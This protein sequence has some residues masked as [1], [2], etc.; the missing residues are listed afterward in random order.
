MEPA[1]HMGHVYL[2]PH[3][4]NKWTTNAIVILVPHYA[5]STATETVSAWPKS[6]VYPFFDVLNQIDFSSESGIANEILKNEPNSRLF[7]LLIFLRFSENEL[8]LKQKCN[9]RLG[10]SVSPEL[11]NFWPYETNHASLLSPID[12]LTMKIVLPIVL[13]IIFTLI[14]IL[15]IC[16]IRRRRYFPNLLYHACL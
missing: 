11:L 13:T 16:A 4:L 10:S 2:P 14:L 12:Y 9:M 15:I 6:L 8:L 7:L 3:S 1:D 5:T